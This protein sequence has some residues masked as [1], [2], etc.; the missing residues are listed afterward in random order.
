MSRLIAD[1]QNLSEKSGGE[2]PRRCGHASFGDA[3]QE[4]AL[5]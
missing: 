1:G 3:L 4:A 5:M 2:F